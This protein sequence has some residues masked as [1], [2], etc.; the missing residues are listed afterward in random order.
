MYFFLNTIYFLIIQS[1]G[2]EGA[3]LF[4]FIMLIP[5]A[6]QQLLM[7]WMSLFFRGLKTNEGVKSE[8]YEI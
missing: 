4:V 5:S 7:S 3:N 1:M 2:E 8:A 6:C